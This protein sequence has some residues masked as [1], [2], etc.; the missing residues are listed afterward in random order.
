MK[1][2]PPPVGWVSETKRKHA[3]I[4]LALISLALLTAMRVLDR[5]LRT[6]D[7]PNGIVS[8]EFAGTAGQASAIIDGWSTDARVA[9]GVSLGLDYLF[10]IAYA[11]TIA[12]ACGMAAEALTARG[13]RLGPWGLR[14][15]WAQ[16]IAAACDMVE[17]L[18]LILLLRG[19]SA[20]G[21][22]ETAWGC[23]AVKFSLVGIGLAYAAAGFLLLNTVFRNTAPKGEIT[24]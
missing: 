23:A 21:L 16:W 6:S 9:A 22:A 12:L 3:L 2:L 18:A 24:P 15:S 10:L 17:N 5:P 4:L 7:A 19:A 20:P 14:L 11:A 13:S 8:F 1:H